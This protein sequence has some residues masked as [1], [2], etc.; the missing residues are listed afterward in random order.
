MRPP[1]LLSH[2]PPGPEKSS[3]PSQYLKRWLLSAK[4]AGGDAATRTTTGSAGTRTGWTAGPDKRSQMLK[5]ISAL[6]ELHRTFNSTLSSRITI[7]PR[8]MDIQIVFAVLLQGLVNDLMWFFIGSDI[9][10]P[11]SGLLV[12]Q[13]FSFNSSLSVKDYLWVCS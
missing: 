7:I 9:I 13:G 5:M 11:Q 6:E 8:G 10:L 2:A 1:L 12:S 3:N 4:A